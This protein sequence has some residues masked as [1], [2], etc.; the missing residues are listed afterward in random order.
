LTPISNDLQQNID[1][2][3]GGQPIASVYNKWILPKGIYDKNAFVTFTP[4]ILNNNLYR[5]G[6]FDDLF[7]RTRGD[8]GFPHGSA[9]GGR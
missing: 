9:T 4:D 3:E 5:T 8:P 6:T 1:K 2:R 7:S